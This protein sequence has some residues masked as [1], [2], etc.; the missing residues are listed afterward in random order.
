MENV[1][2]MGIYNL[3]NVTSSTTMLDQFN[4]VNELTNGAYA[5]LILSAIFVV[6]FVAMK[7]RFDTKDVFLSASFTTTI[8][9]VIFFITGSIGYTVLILPIIILIGAVIAKQFWGD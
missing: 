3:T 7:S 2:K 5:A 1:E 9:A 4:T 6:M 8:V